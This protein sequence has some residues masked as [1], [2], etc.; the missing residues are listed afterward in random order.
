MNL[1]PVRKVAGRRC[2]LEALYLLLADP[3]KPRLVSAALIFIANPLI[4]QLPGRAPAALAARSAYCELP[5]CV[6][7]LRLI[8]VSLHERVV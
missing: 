5:T 8:T 1:G 7:A 4:A 6:V 2:N 3:V